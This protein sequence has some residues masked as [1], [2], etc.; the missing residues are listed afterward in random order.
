[1]TRKQA[2]IKALEIIE[3]S[4]NTD[5]KELIIKH[6]QKIIDKEQNTLWTKESILI[7]IDEWVK[8]HN[9]NPIHKDFQKKNCQNLLLLK[10]NLI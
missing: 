3:L 6:L 10:Q 2:L 7:V 4:Q 1:M 8:N 5:E 9:R